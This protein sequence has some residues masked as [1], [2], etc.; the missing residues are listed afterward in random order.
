MTL[1]NKT[2]TDRA[3]GLVFAL[4][5]GILGLWPMQQGHAPR[6]F[7]LIAGGLLLVI[8]L[9]APHLLH[10]LNRLW[11]AFGELLHRVMNPLIMGILFFVV[12]T[13]ISLAMRLAGK[14]G[15]RLRIDRNVPSY[16]IVRTPPGPEPESCRHQ[17]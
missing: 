7:F 8:A 14:D 13:P 15:L 16:W 11:L 2:G 6:M 10:P 5:F 3:F 12:I 9:I 4:L 1:S 17:F